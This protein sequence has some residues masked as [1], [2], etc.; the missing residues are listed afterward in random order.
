MTQATITTP[1]AGTGSE[2]DPHRPKVFDDH[3][4]QPGASWTDITAAAGGQGATYR[5]SAVLDQ[6]TLNAILADPSY[7]P[8]AVT[9]TNP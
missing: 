6:A 5:V 8:G 9:V 1:W 2:L 3:P 4:L 7:G